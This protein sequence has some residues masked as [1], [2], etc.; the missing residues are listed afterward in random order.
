MPGLTSECTKREFKEKLP[1][2]RKNM[3]YKNDIHLKMF[4]ME[5]RKEF[6]R[7]IWKYGGID[8]E[9]RSIILECQEGGFS[10]MGTWTGAKNTHNG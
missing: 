7:C 8:Y 3:Q 5:E 9:E 10:S 1:E 2:C 4:L 6:I